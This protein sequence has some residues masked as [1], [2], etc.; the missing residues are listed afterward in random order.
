[1][2]VPMVV[3]DAIECVYHKGLVLIFASGVHFI[4]VLRWGVLIKRKDI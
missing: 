2:V 3:E 1:M 4:V